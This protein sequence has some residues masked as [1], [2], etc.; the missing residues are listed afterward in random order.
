MQVFIIMCVIIKGKKLV[1]IIL[2][3]K[4]QQKTQIFGLV[5]KQKKPTKT[6]LK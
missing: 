1:I 6:G 5:L 3:K 2:I 4:Q